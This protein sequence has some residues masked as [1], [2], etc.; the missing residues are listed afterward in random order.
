MFRERVP[1]PTFSTGNAEYVP[2]VVIEP[3]GIGRYPTPV[4]L[5]EAL[6][7]RTVELWVKNDGKS[8]DLYGGNKVRKLELL[9]AD[10]RAKGARRI[11]TAGAAGSHHVL[12]TSIYAKRLGLPTVAVLC[13]QP[14]NEHSESML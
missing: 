2:S 1:A 8:A 3:L 5:A 14:Y 11:V 7:D 9:L 12:A 10:A 6:S 13:P 4:F